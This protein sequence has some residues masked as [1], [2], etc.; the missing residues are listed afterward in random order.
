MNETSLSRA[1]ALAAFSLLATPIAAHAGFVGDTVAA[2]ACYPDLPPGCTTSAGPVQAVVGAGVE[3]TDGQFTPFFGPSFDFAD[4]TITITHAQTGHSSGT[5]N[6]Y[7]FFDVFSTIDDIVGVQ[8]TSDNTGFFSGQPGRV[9]FDANTVFVNFESLNFAGTNTPQIVLT[10]SFANA[11][12]EPGALALLGIGL[13]G[14]AVSRRRN[15]R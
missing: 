11:V 13:A 4:T 15:R 8:I 7:S 9:F 10:V 14:L 6:G 1:L 3:F 2:T 5:F 12:P